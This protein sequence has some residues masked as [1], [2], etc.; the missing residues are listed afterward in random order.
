MYYEIRSIESLPTTD[1]DGRV[2][3]TSGERGAAD[4]VGEGAP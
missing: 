4:A 2:L 3:L 1:S